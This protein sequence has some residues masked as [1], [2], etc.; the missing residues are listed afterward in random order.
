MKLNIFITLILA[1]LLSSCDTQSTTDETVDQQALLNS[2]EIVSSLFKYTKESN[3]NSVY[4]NSNAMSVEK[5]FKVRTTGTIR[6]E[7]CDF[8]EGFGRSTIEGVG[9]ATHL[10][11]F[12]ITLSY[13]FNEQGPVEYIYAT[14]T[15]ANGDQVYSVV[16]GNNPEVQSIDFMIYDGTGRFENAT[17]F[18][19]LF[20]EFDYEN[21][22]FSNHGEGTLTY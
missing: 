12:T 18:I 16:V 9:N 3:P 7:A 6:M 1:G 4:K 19:T 11:R 17:G 2:R 14:Q 5:N 20:F 21:G 15:A 8:G 10:G 22:T 13:C